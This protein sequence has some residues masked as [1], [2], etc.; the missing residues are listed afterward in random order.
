M[1]DFP[2]RQ[3]QRFQIGS[4]EVILI[5]RPIDDIVSTLETLGEVLAA[6][7]CFFLTFAS[8]HFLQMHCRSR[9]GAIHLLKFTGLPWESIQGTPAVANHFLLDSAM[10][11]ASTERCCTAGYLQA[12]PPKIRHFTVLADKPCSHLSKTACANAARGAQVQAADYR[13]PVA[14]GEADLL[15]LTSAFARFALSSV[16][17]GQELRRSCLKQAAQQPGQCCLGLHSPCRRE[18]FLLHHADSTR[19]QGGIS[20]FSFGVAVSAHMEHKSSPHC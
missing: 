1:L 15:S 19:L 8:V 18:R 10:W 13:F 4:S 20:V 7:D 9:P 11:C 14:R 16:Y 6:P 3:Q 5:D 2:G 12:P 17:R